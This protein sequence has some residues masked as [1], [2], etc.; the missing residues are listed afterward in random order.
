MDMARHRLRKWYSCSVH[1]HDVVE[2]LRP[3]VPRLEEEDTPVPPAELADWISVEAED[4]PEV[5]EHGW[6]VDLDDAV[7]LLVH[8][9]RDDVAAALERQAGVRS[10]VQLDREVF[11]VR[12][13][14]LC[15]DG[16]RAVVL[17]AVAAAHDRAHNPGPTVPDRPLGT[18]A[19]PPPA[20][21]TPPTAEPPGEDGFAARLV[22]G[23]ARCGGRSVQLWVNQD[24]LLVLPTGAIPHGPLDPSE[25]PRFQR[26]F[27]DFAR[28]AGLA[29]QHAG[30]WVPYPALRK[31]E[32]RRPGLVRRRWRVTIVER[33]GD[34]ASLSWA[35]TRPHALLLWGYVVAKCGLERVG[36]LP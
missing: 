29:E 1:T 5:D 24:G 17:Q 28:A 36:G 21:S 7:G 19:D 15:A 31:L 23:D 34:S 3:L 32:L 27:F 16:V 9:D 13:P 25:N 10:V 30:R 12:A 33:S 26:A 4:D 20:A 22:T 35:G 2:R 11:A 14:S 18:P 8:P 6:R